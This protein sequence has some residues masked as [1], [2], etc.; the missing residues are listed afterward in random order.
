VGLARA[1]ERGVD[2]HERRA[3]C[4]GLRQQ[5]LEFA[6]LTG[7]GDDQLAAA[8]VR[9]PRRFA[10]RVEPA[11]ALDR[12]PRLER[13]GRVVEP[14][15][16]HA[17]VV[18]G[19]LEPRARVALED[20]HR[21]TTPGHGQAGRQPHEAAADDGDHR[22]IPPGTSAIIVSRCLRNAR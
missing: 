15:V 2:R 10:E 8:D 20:R 21:E 13:P 7:P 17:A 11:S 14:G 22:D 16:D 6:G 9:H 19:R 3:V 1:D 5:P 18:R 12:Q 4:G